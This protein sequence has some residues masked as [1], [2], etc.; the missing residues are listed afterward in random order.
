VLLG[1]GDGGF[2][3]DQVLAVG[4]GAQGL[5]VADV[6]GDGRPDIVTANSLSDDVSVL[7]AAGQP[8]CAG[9]CDGNGQVTVDEILRG[10][11]VA[12]GA[13]TIAAC[14]VAD[15]DGDGQVTI[16]ELIGAVNAALSGCAAL[17]TSRSPTATT[18]SAPTR[19]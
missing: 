8:I 9:D 12:L 16:D 15:G 1:S 14:V 13:A 5:A 2:T 4:E 19:R 3:L 7:L 11:N 10:V 6:N 18:S 17:G